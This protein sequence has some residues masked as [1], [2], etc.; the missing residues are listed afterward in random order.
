MECP[1]TIGGMKVICFGTIDS[2]QRHTKHT[3]QVIAHKSIGPLRRLVICEGLGNHSFYMFGCNDLWASITDTWHQS[4][5]DAQAH[6][7]SEYAGVSETWK[8]KP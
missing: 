1:G 3:R 2:Q 5:K 8:F 6:A 4:L 7:E